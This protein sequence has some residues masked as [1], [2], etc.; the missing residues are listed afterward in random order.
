MAGQQHPFPSGFPTPQQQAMR[1]QFAGGQMVPGLMGPQQT[2][3]QDYN[4]Y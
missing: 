4:Q 1:T 3:K 2:G